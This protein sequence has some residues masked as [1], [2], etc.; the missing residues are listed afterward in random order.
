VAVRVDSQA[1][2]EQIIKVMDAARD[3]KLTN[4]TAFVKGPGK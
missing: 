3:A 2:F 4:F 1:P